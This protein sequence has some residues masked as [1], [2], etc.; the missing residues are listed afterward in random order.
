MRVFVT[1]SAT[2]KNDTK[3]KHYISDNRYAGSH[4]PTFAVRIRRPTG[5]SPDHCGRRIIVQRSAPAAE[6]R[7]LTKYNLYKRATL[8]Q[9]FSL[10]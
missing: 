7:G 5:R 10:A 4:F 8:E 1:C 3:F 6:E 2:Q 9:N